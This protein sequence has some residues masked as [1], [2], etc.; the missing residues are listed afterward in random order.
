MKRQIKDK[1]GFTLM[2]MLIVVAIIAVLVAIAIPTVTGQLHNA[3]VAADWANV[4]AYYAEIQADYIANDG[5]NDNVPNAHA[6][7]TLG[8]YNVQTDFE[9]IT[10]LNGTKVKLQAGIYYIIHSSDKGIESGYQILYM[11]KNGDPNCELIL[12]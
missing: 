4:R 12:K 11:C 2:E 10:F 6:N 7:T 1:K 3:K 8:E 9:N 5:Y